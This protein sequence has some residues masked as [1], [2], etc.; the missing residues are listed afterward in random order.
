MATSRTSRRRSPRSLGTSPR[1]AARRSRGSSSRPIHSRRPRSLPATCRA[2]WRSPNRPPQ[3]GRGRW[4]RPSGSPTSWRRRPRVRVRRRRTGRPGPGRGAVRA[5]GLG[6]PRQRRRGHV[7]GGSPV[8]EMSVFGGK[9]TTTSRFT[10][11]RASSR[12]ART[13]YRAAC[14]H[15]RDRRAVL[16]GGAPRATARQGRG[17]HLRGVRGGADRGGQDHRRGRAR[18]RWGRGLH[19]GRGARRGTGGVVG[20]TRAA[21]DS[22]GS[23]T[24]SRSARPARS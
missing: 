23:R 9:L 14:G 18:R 22:A 11:E 4:S 6:R 2:S 8:V 19:A 5:H 16:F 17:A 24:A 21:V 13:W 1:R 7:G 3:T 10:T 20:A 15:G 12:S